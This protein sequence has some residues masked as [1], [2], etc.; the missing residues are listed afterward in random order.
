MKVQA[1]RA[2]D[3]DDLEA[4]WPHCSFPSPEAAAEA[5]VAAYPLESHDPFMAE[6][7]TSVA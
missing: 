4:R 5:L 2:V 7:I 1:G 3:S 6:W